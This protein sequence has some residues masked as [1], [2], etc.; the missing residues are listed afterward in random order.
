V[1][2]VESQRT[3][4]WACA[5]P[6]KPGSLTWRYRARRVPTFSCSVNTTGIAVASGYAQLAGRHLL[7]DLGQRRERLDAVARLDLAEG[8]DLEGL[9]GVLPARSKVCDVIEEEDAERT[10]CRRTTPPDACLCR[11]KR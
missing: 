5:R 3:C 2:T 6:A 9:D 1:A 7:E 10:D 8:G 4:Q 11:D